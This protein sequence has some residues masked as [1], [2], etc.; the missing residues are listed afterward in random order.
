MKL[1]SNKFADLEVEEKIQE[2]LLNRLDK[3]KWSYF[4]LDLN[5]AYK[6]FEYC[7]DENPIIDF[8]KSIN[9][10]H[11]GKFNYL[12]D[13]QEKE[14]LQILLTII[15]SNPRILKDVLLRL[16]D[17]NEI[18]NQSNSNDGKLGKFNRKDR[19]YRNKLYKHKIANGHRTLKDNVV[20][21]AEGDSWFQF[22]RVY[23]KIDPVKD[24]IDWLIDHPKYAVYSLAAGGD[25]L[26]NIFYSGEYVEELP[27]VSPDVFLISGGGN[28]LVGNNR[29]ASMVINPKLEDKRKLVKG[30]LLDKLYKMR[31]NDKII[32]AKKYLRGLRFISDEFFTFLNLYFV[33]YFV[34]LF[35][36]SQVEKY[37]KMIIIT[38]GY[39]FALPNDKSRGNFLSIQRIINDFTDTGHWLYQPLNM[40]GI[41]NKKDQEAIIY[42][43]IYEF[44]E[45]M[46]QLAT[47]N[48][49]P[50]LFHIDCRG[51][52]TEDDWFDELHLK[53][54]GFKDITK[55]YKNCI[56]QNLRMKNDKPKKKV[57]KVK[58]LLKR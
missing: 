16:F 56:T 49:L 12:G 46:I 58:E 54:D 7:K 39:D 31:K 10:T 53:S 21:L 2:L 50:N 26:S 43:M 42:T 40:K 25:W 27:K 5:K 20:I 17:I 44:N 45:M 19:E 30:S 48:G 9:R 15:K 22:P 55:V 28:D 33:Q 13:F 57:Y 41:T 52:A 1:E 47:F 6:N 4:S 23:F 11:L 8:F 37:K 14:V 29:L 35:S 36:L 32:D 34:F 51:Y 24:I 3:L 38:Q 18:K